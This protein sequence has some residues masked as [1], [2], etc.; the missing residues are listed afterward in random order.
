ME[1]IRP[2]LGCEVDHPACK[3]PEFRAKIVCLD[4]EF[5]DRILRGDQSK[6]VEVVYMY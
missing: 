6:K 1:G 3:P 2:R 4:L 5:L